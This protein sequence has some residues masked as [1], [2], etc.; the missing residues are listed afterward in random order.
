MFDLRLWRLDILQFTQCC[1]Q[2]LADL[3]DAD[4]FSMSFNRESASVFSM[5]LTSLVEKWF[6]PWGQK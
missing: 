4:L 2:A 1:D 5:E 6:R 3:A